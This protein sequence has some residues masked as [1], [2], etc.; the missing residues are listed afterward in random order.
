M[1]L[2]G[3]AAI[4]TSRST[5]ATPAGGPPARPASRRR[6][7]AAAVLAVVIMATAW[8]PP[9]TAA[10]S[11]WSRNLWVPSAYVSQDPYWTGCAAAATMF[12]LNVIALR[13]TGGT[14][15]A[16][17]PSRTKRSPDPADDRD[18]TSILAF[19]R[20]N[21]TLRATGLGTDAHGWRNALNAYGW[22]ETATTDPT[23]MVYRDRAYRTFAGA[24]RAA[25]K[26]IA[27]RGMPV[28]ILGW[29]GGHAQVMTGYVVTGAD[30]RVSDDFAVTAVYL[31]DPLRSNDLVNR[32]I[33]WASLRGGA[34]KLRFRAYRE[35]DS[36]YD[37]WLDAGTIASSIRPTTGRSEWYGRWVLVLP[38][39]AGLPAPGPSPDPTPDPTPTAD[40]DPTPA[41]TPVP[42]PTSTPVP[43]APAT[44]A[45]EPSAAPAGDPAGPTPEPS[46]AATTTP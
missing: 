29:A 10:A 21:D 6:G 16:W 44:P 41:P 26:A 8:P 27:R 14:G 4:T 46:P 13:G 9:P 11:T 39:R 22:D 28:G 33:S 37:D 36:P 34:P 20:A 30:P 40:P 38:V 2:R 18:L 24:V 7:I 1:I 3:P 25:V 5:S 12:M 15:F 43:E 42:D 19:A 17:T 35:T 45:V 23:R 32:R 31:S